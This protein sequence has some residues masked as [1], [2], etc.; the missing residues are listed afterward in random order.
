MNI[1]GLRLDCNGR[2][3][4]KKRKKKKTEVDCG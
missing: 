3:K 1:G 2:I 4:D